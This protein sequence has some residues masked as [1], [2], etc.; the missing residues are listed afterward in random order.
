MAS[1]EKIL[2]IDLG[3]T[4]SAAAVYEGSGAISIP[5][6]DGEAVGGKMFPSVVA[7]MPDGS[8]VVG[9]KAKRQMS[10]NPRG[11]VL[12]IKRKMGTEYRVQAHGK[13]YTPEQISALILGKIKSDSEAYLGTTTRK[14]VITVP[15]HFNDNQ[16]QA[17][18]EAGALAGLEV[19]RIINEPT[20][21]CLAYGLDRAA[22]SQ[23]K[24]KIMVFSFGGGTHDV[25]TMEIE[26]ETYKVLATS[27]DTLTGGAD[28]DSAIVERLANQFYNET[29]VNLR[30]SLP[31]MVRLKE[32]AEKAKIELS[33]ELTVEVGVPFLAEV[34]GVQKHL[35]YELTQAELEEIAGPIVKRVERTIRT[36]LIDSRLGAEDI[37]RLILI[38][39]QTKM[40]LVRKVVEQYMGKVAEEGVDPMQCVAIGAAYQ[41][42]VLTGKL[43]YRLL[44]VTPLTLGIE[45]AAGTVQKIIYRNTPIPVSKSQSFTTAQDDQTEVSIHVVQGERLM[46]ADCVS[47]GRF[48]LEGFASRPRGTT[49][50]LVG[51]EIDANGMMH[52]SA[53]ELSSGVEQRVNIT[54]KM[55]ISEE[56][57]KRLIE[58]SKMFA[59]IDRARKEEALLTSNAGQLI[60]KAKKIQEELYIPEERISML[61]KV[62]ADLKGVMELPLDYSE[63][64]RKLESL[65]AKMVE[66]ADLINDTIDVYEM[67]EGA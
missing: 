62:S 19:I 66:L 34:G 54:G 12:E 30:D 28:I 48:D 65:K 47:I 37:D 24:M 35:K 11:T 16:R 9:E 17:T 1:A 21:A 56:E 33:G 44:D 36:V 10:V 40:P 3:T 57:R 45:D 43:N 52:V 63:E 13:E 55:K 42:A 31:A 5:S 23:G 64:N 25:T 26:G 6:Q 2:G 60:Y 41:G 7:F 61:N 53:K 51:F 29:G 58:E 18:M 8:V 59:G 49:Q 15:A 50:I 32:A 4:N 38:G 20:A 14:A 22:V 67:G 39:G 46:A 27:G